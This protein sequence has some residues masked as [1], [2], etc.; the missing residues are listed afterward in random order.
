MFGGA[1]WQNGARRG[2][3]TMSNQ[4]LDAHVHVG[5]W[6]DPILRHTSTTITQLDE[7]L[8]AVGISGAVVTTSDRRENTALVEE[9]ERDATLHYWFFPWVDPGPGAAE[10]VNFLQAH[11]PR[12]SGVKLHPSL[13][14][15]RVT[16]A[17]YIPFLDFASSERLP[18]LVHCGQWQEMASYRFVLELAER[19]PQTNFV[20]A[21]GGGNNA[22]LRLEAPMEIER[23]GSPQNIFIDLTGLGLWWTAEIAIERLGADRFL[24]GSDFPL[25]HPKV[26]LGLVDALRIPAADKDLILGQNLLR[27]LEA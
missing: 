2:N 25:G 17:S 13:S 1:V 6:D 21:H 18:V 3:N 14:R 19:Y 12:I 24:Y 5:S 16:D 27:L 7:L 22:A 20:M 4:V 11:R 10:D 23:R 8:A 26:L 15:V 9:I